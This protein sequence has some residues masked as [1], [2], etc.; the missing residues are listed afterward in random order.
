MSNG[1][2]KQLR[3]WL[4]TLARD[5]EWIL[6]KFSKHEALIV[7]IVDRLFSANRVGKNVVVALQTELCVLVLA[8]YQVEVAD[9][10]LSDIKFVC[11]RGLIVFANAIFEHFTIDQDQLLREERQITVD[12]RVACRN[13]VFFHRERVS[14]SEDLLLAKLISQLVLA[15]GR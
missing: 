10:M 12:D 11:I 15:P 9:G 4:A 13:A 6:G 2:L 1:H 3:D 7:H 14:V 8:V 5:S